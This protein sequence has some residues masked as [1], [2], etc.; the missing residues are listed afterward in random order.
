MCDC[1]TKVCLTLKVQVYTFLALT[2]RHSGESRELLSRSE[3]NNNNNTN[4]NN[5][6]NSNTNSVMEAHS[7]YYYADSMIIQVKGTKLQYSH[8]AVD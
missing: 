3:F 4:T 2:N 1:I 8:I 6:N 5:D 7:Y